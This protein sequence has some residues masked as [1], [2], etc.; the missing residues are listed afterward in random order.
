MIFKFGFK[1]VLLSRRMRGYSCG[2]GYIKESICI[3]IEKE[4]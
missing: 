1:R 3:R 2:M 4:R